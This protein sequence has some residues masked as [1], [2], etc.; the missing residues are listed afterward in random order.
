MFLTIIFL[1]IAV[2]VVVLGV[3]KVS[4]SRRRLRRYDEFGEDDFDDYGGSA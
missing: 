1:L 4:A 2:L 3:A